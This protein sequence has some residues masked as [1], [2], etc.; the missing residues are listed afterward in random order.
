MNIYNRFLHENNTLLLSWKKI[1]MKKHVFQ[2]WN[3][4]FKTFALRKAKAIYSFDLSVCKELN[5][6]SE[7]YQNENLS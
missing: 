5:M 7:K 6:E 3:W 1:C 4:V 2:I